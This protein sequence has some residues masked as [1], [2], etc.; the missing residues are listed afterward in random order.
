VFTMSANRSAERWSLEAA[1]P[2]R[3]FRQPP[4]WAMFEYPSTR[5]VRLD[6]RQ[7]ENYRMGGEL[8]GNCYASC[9]LDR[10]TLPDEL[11]ILNQTDHDIIRF[12]AQLPPPVPS[13]EG[14]EVKPIV[15]E[16]SYE[17]SRGGGR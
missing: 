7:Y 5:E 16:P 15:F 1:W 4:R 17:C 8:S 3:R 13:A 6:R 12:F 9:L 10:Q 11:T 2:P 14:E